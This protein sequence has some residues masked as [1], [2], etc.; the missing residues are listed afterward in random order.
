M[1]S[2]GARG[3]S[4]PAPDPN[5][6]RQSGEF[7]ELPPR[8]VGD[9]PVWPLID[10]TE[11]EAKLWADLWVKPQAIIWERDQMF[12]LV[13]FYVRQFAEAE[14]ADAAVNRATLVKQLAGE[15]MLT[16]DGLARQRLRISKVEPDSVPVK[17]GAAKAGSARGRLKVVNGGGG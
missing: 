15:L 3:R 4:G 14:K 1:A 10:Q 11:R 7:T 16:P 12:E 9:V 6:L 17:K 13:A 8:R 2:G 5:A